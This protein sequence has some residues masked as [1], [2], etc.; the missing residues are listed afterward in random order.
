MLAAIALTGLAGCA[1]RYEVRVDALS[2]GT[3]PAG[4]T[5]R[6]ASDT[7]GVE[8]DE[9]FFTEVARHLDPLLASQGLRPAPEGAAA[10][11]RIGVR[12][13]LSDPKIQTQSYSDP[14][15]LESPGYSRVVRVPVV[16]GDGK[17]VRYVYSQYWSPPRFSFSGYVQRD[18]Q[19]T[20]YDKILGLSARA[21]DAGG[22]TGPEVWAL[23]VSLLDTGTDYRA[24]LPY[25]VVAARPWIGRRSNGEEVIV[26]RDNAPEITGYHTRLDDGR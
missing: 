6:L 5:Y 25:L 23:T 14:I 24:A 9:L 17:V 1:T 8:E 21:L 15:Y 3:G 7:P 2:A 10:D 18:R 13:H 11:L 22:K 26:I 4:Q 16:S 19:I 12:A 20:V